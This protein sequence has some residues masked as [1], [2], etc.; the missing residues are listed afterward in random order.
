M[1]DGRTSVVG[2]QAVVLVTF[3]LAMMLAGCST[4][5][6]LPA[7]GV[8]DDQYLVGGGLVI[9][10][11]APA[12]GTAYLV[13]KTTG[14]IIETRSME[15]GDN[16]GFSVASEA[17]AREFGKILGIDFSDALFWLYFKPDDH[18]GARY[19]KVQ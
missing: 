13:E 5:R 17:Q 7:S 4:P 2:K 11:K 6:Y 19:P 9:D 16:F 15:A 10:W 1:T 8:P 18:S 3:G 14:K 12:D